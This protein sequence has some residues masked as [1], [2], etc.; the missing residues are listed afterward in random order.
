MRFMML[1]VRMLNCASGRVDIP[2]KLA[3]IPKQCGWPMK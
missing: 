2:Y 3:T 1:V